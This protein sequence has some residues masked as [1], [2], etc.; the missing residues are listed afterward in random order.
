M[1]ARLRGR[2]WQ[3]PLGIFTGVFAAWFV[4]TVCCFLVPGKV[5]GFM[6]VT[7]N[8]VLTPVAVFGA[9]GFVIWYWVKHR[10]EGWR[11]LGECAL[12]LVL[13]CGVLW[14]AASGRQVIVYEAL[15]LHLGQ[16]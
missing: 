12:A 13:L 16:E 5:A 7:V 4:L 8:F 11:V 15:G 14:I 2:I 10:T 9:G 3:R 1:S 6:F